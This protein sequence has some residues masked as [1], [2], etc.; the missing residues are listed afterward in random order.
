[1][2]WSTR[3]L[4][5]LAGTTVNAVRHYHRLGLLA[6]PERRHNGYKQ[7]GVRDLVS[8]LRIRRLVELGVPLAQIGDAIDA[9]GADREI[10][11][12]LDA[13]LAAQID[14]LTRARVELADI[15]RDEAPADAPAGF[16]AV[17]GRLSEADSS[18]LHIYS[19]VYDPAVMS[20]VRRMVEEDAAT[21]TASR[22]VDEL[23]PDADEATRERLS[24]ELAPII[25]QYMRDYAWVSDPES[26][27]VGSPDTDKSTVT[28]ALVELYNPAQLDVYARASALARE[29]I[30]Q[31]SGAEE[32]GTA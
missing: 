16:S 12:N 13:D 3:E 26:H 14:R 5:D 1:M 31:E 28:A 7:Y 20:D 10:L 23:A 29:V 19:R 32:T 2:A 6:E 17:A 22:E 18:I 27:F 15:M 4:A 21:G 25:A 11:Q 24:A 8:L 30:A 9:G